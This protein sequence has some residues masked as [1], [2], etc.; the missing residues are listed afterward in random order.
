M[1]WISRKKNLLIIQEHY[2]KKERRCH[3]HH[4]KDI[5]NCS[6]KCE[7]YFSFR[8][9]LHWL[10]VLNFTEFIKYK[11]V[12]MNNITVVKIQ[13]NKKRSNSKF[14]DLLSRSKILILKWY[15]KTHRFWNTTVF[16]RF[17]Y[18]NTLLTDCNKLTAHFESAS[19]HF[20]T[21]G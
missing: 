17:G 11:N 18:N 5:M 1:W 14:D 8:F 6:F 15:Y 4:I 12:S 7:N 10:Y 3:V 21:A 2:H 19:Q 13:Q 16:K 20:R 9:L